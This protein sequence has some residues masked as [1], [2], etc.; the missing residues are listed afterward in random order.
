MRLL[1]APF[2]GRLA[3]VFG[4]FRPELALFALAAA[5]DFISDAMLL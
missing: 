2:A 5:N 3:D 4:A 1:S